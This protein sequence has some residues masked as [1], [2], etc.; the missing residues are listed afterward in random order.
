MYFQNKLSTTGSARI[1]EAYAVKAL[2]NIKN[3]V[4]NRFNL[5]VW[6]L[7]EVKNHFGK[8]FMKTYV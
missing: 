5:L 4:I 8:Q 2:K 7:P 3:I 6:A 1:R